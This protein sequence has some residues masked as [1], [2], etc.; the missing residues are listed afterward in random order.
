ME[1]TGHDDI[2]I[3]SQR[4][5]LS[6]CVYKIHGFLHIKAEEENA[7]VNTR[8]QSLVESAHFIDYEK[9][10]AQESFLYSDWDTYST[11]KHFVEDCHPSSLYVI[12]RS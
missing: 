7:D 11:P 3:G 1:S 8:Y 12:A 6:R 4:M 9:H 10:D 2:V 5:A